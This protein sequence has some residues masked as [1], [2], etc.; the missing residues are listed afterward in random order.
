[1]SLQTIVTS[2]GDVEQAQM[3]ERV[4]AVSDDVVEQSLCISHV[5]QQVIDAEAAQTSHVAQQSAQ[6]VKNLSA[7]AVDHRVAGTVAR[8]ARERELHRLQQRH[9]VVVEEL[10]ETRHHLA[11]TNRHCIADSAPVAPF[12]TTTPPLRLQSLRASPT[13]C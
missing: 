1:M 11:T 6:L 13:H 12:V 7:G 8:L 9:R 2:P 3:L 10:E 5:Q 4:S